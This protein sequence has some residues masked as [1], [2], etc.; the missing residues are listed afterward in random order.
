[1][2]KEV[3]LLVGGRSTEHDASVHSYASLRAALRGSR[4]LAVAATVFIDRYGRT[5]IHPGTPGREE[6]DGGAGKSVGSEELLTFLGRGAHI[7]SLLH[8]TEGED[9]GW[10]GVAD[11]FDLSGN[12]GSVDAAALSMNKLACAA[13]VAVLESGLC[14]PKTFAVRTDASA[15]DIKTACQGLAGKRCVVKPNSLGASLM[16]D[17]LV[18]P[19]E[20]FIAELVARLAPHDRQAL[21]QEYI[22]GDE[23][24]VGVVEDEEGISI[25]PPARA[26]LR[27]PILGHREKHTKDGGVTVDWP[28]PD[29]DLGRFLAD[30]S[31]RLFRA[32]GLR[33]WARFDFI[34]RES[35]CEV[36]FLE[37][38]LMPGLG[39]GSIY[40]VMLGHAGLTLEDLVA[41]SVR[42]ASGRPAGGKVLEY[43]IEAHEISGA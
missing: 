42:L 29:S 40:P 28:D 15:S 32:L 5:K 23:I 11:V 9:G 19:E 7:F 37:V 3:V 31:A 34:V 6:L 35:P 24:T 14:I 22:D 20:A 36:Y 26:R 41:A 43:T 18:E 17:F 38:N 13:T 25:L 8:G 33:L 4:R 21:V 10:Q 1:M 39:P 2:L 16:T 30:V 12:F 27:S